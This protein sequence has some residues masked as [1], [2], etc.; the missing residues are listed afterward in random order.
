MP[1]APIFDG[2]SEPKTNWYRLP[3]DWFD[4]WIRIRQEYGSRFAALLK[5]LE[6][7][8]IHTW[9]AG[10]FNGSVQ[11]SAD[12]IRNGRRIKKDK[13][14]DQGT[15]ISENAVRRAG[16][17]LE[18]FGLLEIKKD[19][20]DKARQLRTYTPRM[21]EQRDEKDPN[22]NSS[23]FTSPRENYFKV[24]KS[25]ALVIRSI[26]S[27]ATILIVE[28][29]FRHAWGY[30]NPGGVWLTVEEIAH[31]RQYSD[32]RKYDNGTGFGISTIHRAL[33]EAI[34]LN[35]I[36]WEERYEAG[37]SFRRYNLYLKGMPVDSQGQY[38]A[39][40]DKAKEVVSSVIDNNQKISKKD[41]EI[42]DEDIKNT[43]ED[44]GSANE[45]RS[46]GGH[47]LT[48]T[49]NKH[50]FKTPSSGQQSKKRK[51]HKSK[52]A[53]DGDGSD[54]LPLPNE[55][56]SLLQKMGWNDS[57]GIIQEHY[58]NNPQRTITWAKC[59]LEKPGLT[60]RAGYF[61]KRLASGEHPPPEVKNNSG[62]DRDRNRYTTGKYADFID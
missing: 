40:T 15:G 4:I 26:K 22:E 2:F 14:L 20:R 35:L 57:F 46:D 16:D 5:M 34:Q 28:Y 49:K 17:F 1:N 27:A 23:G 32:G 60:S 51:R 36:V 21:K 50:S 42:A 18:K 47:T 6:Y 31:G 54:L 8:L 58:T 61:R 53:R 41:I 43:N 7:I 10:R 44:T 39:N 56:L 45:A 48:N 29:L 12:E 11:I 37:I 52:R 3:N 38:L 33:D 13:R 19:G 9:G 24:P 30:Q 62:K 55:L 25:W 59:A